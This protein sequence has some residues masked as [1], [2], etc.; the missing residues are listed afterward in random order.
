MLN[1][2][3]KKLVTLSETGLKLGCFRYLFVQ[4]VHNSL[5]TVFSFPPQ[6]RKLYHVVISQYLSLRVLSQHSLQLCNAV[7]VGIYV[8]Q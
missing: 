2:E 6:A 3:E 1:R 4:S 7:K 5:L 8:K